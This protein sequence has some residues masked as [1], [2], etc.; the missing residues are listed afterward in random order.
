MAR[1]SIDFLFDY[2]AT[3]ERRLAQIPDIGPV[4]KPES[5]TSLSEQDPYYMARA[6][7]L[8]R[9]SGQTKPPKP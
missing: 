8:L 5:L 7:A 9:Y 3:L 6:A 1:E 4:I 2:V